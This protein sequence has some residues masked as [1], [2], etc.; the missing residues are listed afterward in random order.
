[1]AATIDLSKAHLVRVHG[2]ITA[3]YSYIND[4]RALILAP[5]FRPGAPWF[6][7]L[8]SAAY[9]WDDEDPNNIIEVVRK[10]NKACEVLGIEPTPHNA[11]RIAGIVIDGLPDLIRMPTAAEKE[12]RNSAYGRLQLK[13]NGETIAE[14]DLRLE[15][16]TGAEYA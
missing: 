11:R 16:E 10:A 15:K 1:M 3:I 5:S 12:L 14:E 6:C 13:A 4:E 2:D 8:E 7:V 9:T